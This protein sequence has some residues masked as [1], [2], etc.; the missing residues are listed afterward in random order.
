MTEPTAT[1]PPPGFR[2]VQMIPMLLF[3]VILPIAVFNVLT[4]YGVSTLWALVAGGVSPATNNLRNWVKSRRLEPLG[5]IVMALLAAGAAGSLISGSV[6]FALIKESFL[7]GVFGAI[8][9]GS[10][11]V[12]RPLLF[13]IVRQFVAGEDA[14]RLAWWNGLWQYP[15]FRRGMRFVTFVWGIAYIAEALLRVVFAITLTPAQVV[16]ISPVM[17]FGILIVLIVWTQR[18]MLAVRDRNMRRAA[19]NTQSA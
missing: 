4:H 13:Y 12:Q 17:G 5:I 16:M 7:T 2:F 6:F 9:L 11:F 14:E 3:D 19:A 18:H 15:D 10:L 1:K 8:C